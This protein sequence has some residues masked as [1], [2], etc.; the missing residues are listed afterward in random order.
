G[1]AL[2]VR[3]G[4]DPQ[5]FAPRLERLRDILGRSSG[6][7]L[8]GQ[9]E[10]EYWQAGREFTWLEAAHTLVK[11][12]VTPRQVAALDERLAEHGAARRY[13]AGANLAWVAW[14]GEL[15]ALD[16]ILQGTGLPALAVLGPAGQ[17]RLGAQVGAAFEARVKQAM[18]PAGKWLSL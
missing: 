4:G 7:Q 15:V 16:Q 5:S 10:R 14:P 12:P 8:E 13:S 11:I 18:D 1:A 9:S 3:L 6:D 17:A 2:L